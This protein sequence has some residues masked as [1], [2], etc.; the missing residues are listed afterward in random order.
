MGFNIYLKSIKEKDFYK[1]FQKFVDKLFFYAILFDVG[2]KIF[3]RL[4]DWG[5][6]VNGFRSRY[7]PYPFPGIPSDLRKYADLRGSGIAFTDQKIVLKIFLAA[8]A[9]DRK[10]KNSSGNVLC[11]TTEELRR[12]M[13]WKING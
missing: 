8:S 11:P 13:L 4:A 6:G 12:R 7:A 1:I 2:I 9:A 5:G 3:I 10:K